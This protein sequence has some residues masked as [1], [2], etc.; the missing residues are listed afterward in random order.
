MVGSNDVPVNVLYAYVSLVFYINLVPQTI[1][2]IDIVREIRTGC[3]R[4]WSW[5]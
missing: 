2:C 4:E 5:L 1:A 3:I